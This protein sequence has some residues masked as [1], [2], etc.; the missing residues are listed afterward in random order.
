MGMDM[1]DPERRRYVPSRIWGPHGYNRR[2]L[3]CYINDNRF[4][5]GR[6]DKCRICECYSCDPNEKIKLAACSATR[7]CSC[8]ARTAHRNSII[9][10]T[11]GACRNNGYANAR[12][13]VGVF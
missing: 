12:A 3:E 2:E 8:G 4:V 10:A 11:D 7:I 5:L 1:F 9:I 6:C 13:A